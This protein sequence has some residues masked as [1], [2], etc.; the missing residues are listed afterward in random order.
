MSNDN[1]GLTG[2]LLIQLWDEDGNLK[3][4]ETVKNLITTAGDLYYATRGAAAVVPATPADATKVTGMKLGT[5]NTAVAKSGTGSKLAAYLPGS[6]VVF[7][8]TYP[9]VTAVG[10]DGGYNINYRVTWPAG[11]A[12]S[13]SLVEAVIVNDAAANADSSSANTIARVIF[14]TINKGASDSLTITWTHKFL[15]AP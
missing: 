1:N 12:T 10:G 11:T 4:E 13:A 7:D 2:H 8:A 5:T 3:H 14:S 6:N 9:T 15:G